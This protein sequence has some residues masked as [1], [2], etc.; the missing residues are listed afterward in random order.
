MR[1]DLDHSPDGLD[2]REPRAVAATCIF[3]IV[4]ILVMLSAGYYFI[5]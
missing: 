1:E 4:V 5:A 3:Y 2:S